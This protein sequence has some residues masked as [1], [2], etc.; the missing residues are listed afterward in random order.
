MSSSD[1][2]YTTKEP[3]KPFSE[4]D[5]E[6]AL[7]KLLEEDEFVIVF[8]WRE[9]AFVFMLLYSIAIVEVLLSRKH[10]NTHNQSSRRICQSCG[11]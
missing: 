5:K 7:D 8:S 11:I 6:E 3:H 9:I 10:A 4:I 2:S 1:K